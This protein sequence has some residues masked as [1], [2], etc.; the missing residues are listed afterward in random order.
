[1]ATLTADLLTV[2]LMLNSVISTPHA[3][4]MM[5]DIKNFYL[6]T[7][8]K[9][10]EYLQLRLSNLPDDVIKQYNLCEKEHPKN[11]YMWKYAKECMV[12]RKQDC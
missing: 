11:L 4:W 10:Y 6:S 9:R 3:R 5:V 1:M 7:P 12:S 2:K 8:L